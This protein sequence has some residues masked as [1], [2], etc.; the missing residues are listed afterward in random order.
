MA[1]SYVR[2]TGNG[3]TTSFSLT[4][5]YL[6]QDDIVVKVDG[7]PTSFTW[8]NS[9]TV[10]VSPA[11]ASDTVV[12]VRRITPSDTAVVDFQNGA[13]VTEDQLDANARQSLYVA[14][15]NAD[16]TEG[17][18]I[19]ASDNT[20]DADSHRITNVG[21][22]EDGTDAATKDYV[23]AAIGLS[24][25]DAAEASATAAAASAAAAEAASADAVDAVAAVE[26]VATNAIL[27]DG[28][29]SMTGPLTLSGAPTNDLHAST[30]KYIDDAIAA[31]T[32]SLPKVGDVLITL[33][34]DARTGWVIVNDGTLSKAGAGGT[35]LADA[36]AQP[37]YEYL[38]NNFNDTLCPVS[39]G[40]GVS[41]SAD[42][43]AG[44]TL[45]TTKML[46]RAIVVA[47]A[48]SGLTSRTLG[49]VDG[50]ETVA[51]PL[52]NHTHGAGTLT[53]PGSAAT[54]LD[55]T[56]AKKLGYSATT[57][58]SGALSVSGS[59]A[60]TGDGASPTMSVVQP[61]VHVSVY[62]KL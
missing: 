51:V 6:S 43:S 40:R 16:N 38:W 34:S 41:A 2:Y 4:F 13:V 48:G 35:T 61:Q 22:P 46:G 50:A 47:G 31:L 29:R 26:A 42:F 39:T 52:K 59:T 27:K 60:T 44:K 18:L 19:I 32:P 17:A 24:Y 53:V 21:T 30:K 14:Q 10:H 25:S 7:T 56:T 23:D 8:T 3:V 1:N 57:D 54:S 49:G 55:G 58:D 45:T 15:E 36:T 5:D 37:L 28:S 9:T 12:E 11:P 33:R 62:L 20:Y